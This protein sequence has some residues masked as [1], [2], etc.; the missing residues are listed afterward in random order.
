M[1]KHAI[2]HNPNNKIPRQSFDGQGI[3]FK[4]KQSLIADYFFLAFF[5]AAGFLAGAFLAVFF[6]AA[7]VYLQVV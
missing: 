7:I 4:S 5:F 2:F 6:L 1:A 3:K